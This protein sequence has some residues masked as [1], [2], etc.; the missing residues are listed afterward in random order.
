MSILGRMK[1]RT[2]VVGFL[3]SFLLAFPSAISQTSN[4]SKERGSLGNP[5]AQGKSV[6]AA[7]DQT[8]DSSIQL[9]LDLDQNGDDAC[10]HVLLGNNKLN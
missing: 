4:P 6:S 2:V 7:S 10:L 9:F 3:A 5:L 8:L 1:A